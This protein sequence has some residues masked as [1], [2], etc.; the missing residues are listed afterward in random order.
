MKRQTLIALTVVAITGL[1]VTAAWACDKGSCDDDG[2]GCASPGAGCSV[3]GNQNYFCNQY[4]DEYSLWCCCEKTK[5][6]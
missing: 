2:A 6:T 4:N 3:G 1:G 5:N